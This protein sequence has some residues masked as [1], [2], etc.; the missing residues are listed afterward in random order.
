MQDK[1]TS[2]SI[3]KADRASPGRL[4]ATPVDPSEGDF[5]AVGVV[6]PT[7]RDPV[8]GCELFEDPHCVVGLRI[9]ACEALP[10]ILINAVT[11]ERGFQSQVTYSSSYS[12]LFLI[13]REPEPSAAASSWGLKRWHFLSDRQ[14]QPMQSS[15]EPWSFSS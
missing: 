8:E 13:Q 5:T 9:L 2:N 12:M 14:P 1:G 6:Y 10:S 7:V 15:R 11:A 3:F 4:N